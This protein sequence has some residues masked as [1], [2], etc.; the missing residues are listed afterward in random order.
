MFSDFNVSDM[1]TL[2]FEKLLPRY[3]DET[4]KKVEGQRGDRSGRVYQKFCSLGY[5]DRMS[6]VR[7]KDEDAILGYKHCFLIKY[8]YQKSEKRMV[9]DQMFTLINEGGTKGQ[10]PFE[11]DEA[12]ESPFL[13]IVLLTVGKNPDDAGSS[14]TGSE[15]QDL[16]EAY[17][18]A[19]IETLEQTMKAS[20][21]GCYRIFYTPNC[22]D[23]CIVMRTDRLQSIYDVKEDLTAKKLKQIEKSVCHT[24]SYTLFQLPDK[25]WSDA[26]I[27]KNRELWLE[28][29]LYA[30]EHAVK[31]VMDSLDGK[32]GSTGEVY[33][34]TGS[35]QYALELDFATFASVYPLIW[36]IK[37]GEESDLEQCVEQRTKL[38][39]AL[40]KYVH[41][42][43]CSYMR[44]KY[45]PRISQN[46]SGTNMN[47]LCLTDTELV[48]KYEN[49]VIKF[50]NEKIKKGGYQ[51]SSLRE[52]KVM[53]R[54][55]YYTYNDF[56][57]RQ[58]SWW[59]GVVFYAQLESIM[60][61]VRQ[62]E[63][64]ADK[65]DRNQEKLI[66]HTTRELEQSIFSVNNF[67]KLLQSVN[68]YVVNIPNYEMQT[69][70]NIEK[71]LM[72]YTMYLFEISRN[73]YLQRHGEGVERM[74]PFFLLD[75]NASNIEALPLFCKKT[76]M[77]EDERE[78]QDKKEKGE[79]TWTTLVAV[80][81][82]NY[83]W[84]A[85]IYHVLPMITHEM[86]HTFRYLPRKKRNGFIIDFIIT[87]LSSYMMEQLLEG[88]GIS[89]GNMYYG[90]RERFFLKH[91]KAA[92][93]EELKEFITLY[94]DHMKLED[95]GAYLSIEFFRATGLHEL[96]HQSRQTEELISK[97]MFHIF[98][99]TGMPYM[100]P[101]DIGEGQWKRDDL[102]AYEL[103]FNILLDLIGA[104]EGR[105][106][107]QK[108]VD[109]INELEPMDFCSENGNILAWI[110]DILK[111]F[112]KRGIPTD[113]ILFLPSQLV[114]TWEEND[115]Q[116]QEMEENDEKIKGIIENLKNRKVE[117][118]Q[119]ELNKSVLE[120]E[121]RNKRGELR[122]GE[123]IYSNIRVDIQTEYYEKLS[124][125]VYS[126]GNIMAQIRSRKLDYISSTATAD[127]VESFAR[128]VHRKLHDEYK[129]M[130]K[131]RHTY[132]N[133]WIIYK[134][135]QKLL[136]SLGVINTDPGQFEDNYRLTLRGLSGNMVNSI[137]RDQIQD[138]EE[139]FADY[140]MCKAFSFTAYGY[141]MYYIHIA[142]KK[143]DVPK[144]GLRN[145]TAD[146]IRI[147]LLSL[148]K[149]EVEEGR[150]EKELQEYWEDLKRALVVHKEELSEGYAELCK[151]DSFKELNQDIFEKF[152]E[153]YDSRESLRKRETVKGKRLDREL[154]KQVWIAR[155]VTLLYRNLQLNME[156]NEDTENLDV[157]LCRHVLDVDLHVDGIELWLRKCRE[158]Q[159]L[160]DIGDYYNHY[161]YSSVIEDT[162]KGRCM[163]HQNRFVFEYYR[164]MFDSI[165]GVKAKMDQS[166]GESMEILDF[167]FANTVT[168]Q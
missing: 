52:Q 128:K 41:V 17:K 43:E 48:E 140:G 45:R 90:N 51:V 77:Y 81:C 109:K 145:L 92:V 130:L 59:K 40:K 147:L 11:I 31:E 96:I 110:K 141:F 120:Y 121:N 127:P 163:K 28:L 37:V 2:H 64:L 157:Q 100:G 117:A 56:W 16:I 7:A 118:A 167:L 97:E 73:Y 42:L 103:C 84:F 79:K 94:E 165:Q 66:Q 88:A 23:L 57:F 67:N 78:Y 142:M 129:E 20:G 161:R 35:G 22:A 65:I 102:K 15:Y 47:G 143:R 39:K 34:I 25:Q 63:E 19:C 61:G 144:Y 160:Q 14:R 68:Q 134:E 86:S 105:T 111:S 155:W 114:R 106:R 26:L 5:Y 116:L 72:A 159:N 50:V 168:P 10:D 71:Y 136:T 156:W 98:H 69:K 6:Y 99:I 123:D 91:M 137:I 166:K 83:Q 53:L 150:F 58:S 49:E 132:V 122:Q 55:L 158:D 133:Q 95:L 80:R 3:S 152:M 18:N 146:R 131:N 162:K 124:G 113:A 21:Q 115:K 32:H 85:N 154:Y 125:F 24:T 126:Y 1:R 13:G 164:K 89:C 93:R 148:Y 46:A 104:K 38:Q 29:R 33:G 27:D 75:F 70:V 119:R 44:V 8:P 112:E 107:Y 101:E 108:W 87:R 82:P 4:R 151:I 153:L 74:L 60:S 9:T 138:Y 12:E 139:I 54:E 62:Y 76:F 36:Q 135:N 30:P 149:E